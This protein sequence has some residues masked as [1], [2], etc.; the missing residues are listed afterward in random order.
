[1][2]FDNEQLQHL[3][4]MFEDQRSQMSLDM[5]SILRE[6]LGGIKEKLDRLL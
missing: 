2:A 4:V 3:S 6:E 1:M 5:R